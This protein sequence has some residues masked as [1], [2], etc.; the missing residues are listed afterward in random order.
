MQLTIAQQLGLD[1]TT[2]ANFF[3]NARRRGGHERLHDDDLISGMGSHSG[4]TPPTTPSSL[5]DPTEFAVLTT[6]V[7]SQSQGEEQ[8]SE[9][10]RFE[11]ESRRESLEEQIIMPQQ[12][13]VF[14][15][16]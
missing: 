14:E 1:P 5:A 15:E 9:E 10:A 2:V 6:V 8:G 7:M 3:M 16:L 4:S 12:N 11:E 13:I